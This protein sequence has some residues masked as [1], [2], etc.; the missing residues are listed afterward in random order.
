MNIYMGLHVL[1]PFLGSCASSTF[2]FMYLFNL[3]CL[4]ASMPTRE[5]CILRISSP[6]DYEYEG[7]R[8][9]SGIV[10]EMKAHASP[11]WTPP[12]DEVIELDEDSFN[13][14]ISGSLVLVEFY[15]PW[16]VF[17][18]RPRPEEA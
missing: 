3:R 10:A 17:W 9:V 5:H 13:A 4:H 12:K 7:P 1:D 2:L 14:F 15:A 16:Y 18:K 6:K 8:E 11:T